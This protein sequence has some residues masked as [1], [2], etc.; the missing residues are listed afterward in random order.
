LLWR[1]TRQSIA[2]LT[3]WELSYIDS[4]STQ[5]VNDFFAY[6]QARQAADRNNRFFNQ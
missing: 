4:L 5:D 3:G 1:Y 2:Q 6:R